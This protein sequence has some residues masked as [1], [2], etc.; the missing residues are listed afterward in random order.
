MS[1]VVPKPTPVIELFN[2]FTKNIPKDHVAVI[3]L[4]LLKLWFVPLED[5]IAP[6]TVR[7]VCTDLYMENLVPEIFITNLSGCQRYNFQHIPP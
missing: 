1:Q 2:V 6:N 5:S 3:A 4:A 7:T